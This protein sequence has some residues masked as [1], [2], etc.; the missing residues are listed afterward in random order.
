MSDPHPLGSAGLPVPD[1]IVRGID[2]TLSQIARPGTWWTAAERLAIAGLARQVRAGDPRTPD[3]GL[4]AAAAEAVITVATAAQSITEETVQQAE[5]D[6][7]RVEAFAEIVGVTARTVAVDTVA[8]GIGVP[9]PAFPP[10]TG[11]APTRRVE[12][13]AK[14]RSAFVPMVG[15]ARAATALSAVR[16]ESEAQEDL[17]GALY[18]SYAEMADPVIVKNLPRWQHELVATRTSLHNECFY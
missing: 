1:R 10:L 15:G 5:A 16:V 13:R 2:R 7:V 3:A 8:R 17:H 11:G 18:L 4:P 12:P 6:G 14:R 9:S